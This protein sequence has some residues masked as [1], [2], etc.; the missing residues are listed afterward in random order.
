VISE[1]NGKNLEGSGRDRILRYYPGMALEG[2]GKIRKNVS[3]DSRSLGRDL[4][5]EPPEYEAGVLTTGPR[6]SMPNINIMIMT[7]RRMRWV[8]HVTRMVR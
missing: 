2:L 4:N 5:A 8:G 6:R 1:R 7:P 3:Q